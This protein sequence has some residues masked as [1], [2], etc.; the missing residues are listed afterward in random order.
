MVP[1]LVPTGTHCTAHQ[2][3][4]VKPHPALSLRPVTGTLLVGG[5]GNGTHPYP[6]RCTAMWDSYR[7][8]QPCPAPLSSSCHRYPYWLVVQ[9]TVPTGTR[10][11]AW[12]CAVVRPQSLTSPCPV[13]SILSLV[14]LT[15]GNGS[16]SYRLVPIALHGSMRWFTPTMPCRLCPVSGTLNGQ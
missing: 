1:L 10:C 14:P 4:M 15:V 8:T 11:T 7:Q 3:A 12:K 13:A 5:T 16:Y 6:L 9:L 2:H